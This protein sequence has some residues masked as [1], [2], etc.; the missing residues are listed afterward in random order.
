MPSEEQETRSFPTSITAT[1]IVSD[2]A[3]YNTLYATM[4]CTKM[5]KSFFLLLLF[6]W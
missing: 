2:M 6:F 5:A 1:I 4:Q 3:M